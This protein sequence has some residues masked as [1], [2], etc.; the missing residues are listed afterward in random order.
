VVHIALDIMVDLNALSGQASREAVQVEEVT[1]RGG[2]VLPGR[3]RRMCAAAL[4]WRR[5]PSARAGDELW[6]R[7][8]RRLGG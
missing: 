7:L 2:T 8:R 1:A 4:L 5:R 3:H 6:G